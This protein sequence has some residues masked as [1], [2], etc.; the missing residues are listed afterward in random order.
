LATPYVIHNPFAGEAYILD[1]GLVFANANNPIFNGDDDLLQATILHE[2]LHSEV[3][4]L[5][6]RIFTF[7]N[8]GA[9]DDHKLVRA[10]EKS[11]LDY[12]LKNGPG[13][14]RFREVFP[15]Q[16]PGLPD[17]DIFRDKVRAEIKR[18]Q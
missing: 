1:R 15:E 13:F 8:S 17:L 4:L 16:V 14:A 6:E 2:R 10:F 9:F 5:E 12:L 18:N 3:A 7:E 11:Y